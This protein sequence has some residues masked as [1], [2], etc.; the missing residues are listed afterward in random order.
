MHRVGTAQSVQ[1][2]IFMRILSKIMLIK[3]KNKYV[4]TFNPLIAP[5]PPGHSSKMAKDQIKRPEKY[6]S[7]LIMNLPL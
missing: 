2:M 3:S 1:S 6:H 5:S 7:A 4:D